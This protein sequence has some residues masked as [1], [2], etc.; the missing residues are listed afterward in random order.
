MGFLVLVLV[1]NLILKSGRTI[2]A[3]S[4]RESGFVFE[5]PC[6]LLVQVLSSFNLEGVRQSLV[7]SCLETWSLQATGGS[8]YVL[9]RGINFLTV[10]DRPTFSRNVG[11]LG[12]FCRLFSGFAYDFVIAFCQPVRIFDW[13]HTSNSK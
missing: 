2:T 10:A 11:G 3:D 4:D 5:S 7:F 12:D 8:L 1:L 13:Y 6:T 9:C